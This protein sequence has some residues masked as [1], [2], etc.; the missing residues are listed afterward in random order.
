MKTD[1]ELEAFAAQVRECANLPHDE[2]FKRCAEI[3]DVLTPKEVNRLLALMHR[4]K[5]NAEIARERTLKRL[6]A[7]SN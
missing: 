1:A 2:F 5:E 3:C 7:E 6:I 4:Y